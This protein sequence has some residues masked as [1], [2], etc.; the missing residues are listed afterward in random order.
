MRFI[1][2][3]RKSATDAASEAQKRV[4]VQRRRWAISNLGKERDAAA[5]AVGNRTVEKVRDGSLQD[6]ELAGLARTVTDADTR[7]E[8]AQAELEGIRA[9]KA[10]Q[11]EDA[12]I[13]GEEAAASP[14]IG[15]VCSNCGAV[16]PRGAQACISCG[17]PVAGTSRQDASTSTAESPPTGSIETQ[18]LDDHQTEARSSEPTEAVTGDAAASG[19]KLCTNCGSPVGEGEST[20]TNCGAPVQPPS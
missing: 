10:E 3:A 9:G 7:I 8:E 1:D 6:D 15:A 20:C 17:A 11:S 18:M 13:S 16:L 4:Q 14:T 5:L 2:S 19:P 12:T